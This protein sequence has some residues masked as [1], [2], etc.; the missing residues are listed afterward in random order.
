MD[1]SSPR[2]APTFIEQSSTLLSIPTAQPNPATAIPAGFSQMRYPF[3]V[4]NSD[5][6]DRHSET[7]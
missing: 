1:P 5:L 7:D 6:I 3:A 4:A 2:Y